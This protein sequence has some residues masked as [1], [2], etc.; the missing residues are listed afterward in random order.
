[1]FA[2]D[3]QYKNK[4]KQKKQPIKAM[5]DLFYKCGFFT[6]ISETLVKCIER[7]NATYNIRQGLSKNIPHLF[8]VLYTGHVLSVKQSAYSARRNVFFLPSPQCFPFWKASHLFFSTCAKLELAPL[9]RDTS[10]TAA[11]F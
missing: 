4:K 1:M 9:P 6:I 8:S 7:R 5:S 10:P 11:A 3:I 2:F